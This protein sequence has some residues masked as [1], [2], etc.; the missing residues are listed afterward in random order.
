MR[1]LNRPSL[2]G[3]LAGAALLALGAGVGAVGC[4]GP[5]ASAQLERARDAYNDARGQFASCGAPYEEKSAELFLE[6]AET[7]WAEHHGE[8]A[9]RFAT[10]SEEKSKA[11]IKKNDEEKAKGRSKCAPYH[12]REG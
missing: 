9:E 2:G 4:T 1:H 7:E 11:A 5:D 12:E 8:A 6:K 3:R 10:M